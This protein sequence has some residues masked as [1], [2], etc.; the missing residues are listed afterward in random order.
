MEKLLNQLYDHCLTGELASVGIVLEWYWMQP[1]YV[2]YGVFGTV[3][4]KDIWGHGNLSDEVEDAVLWL[5]FDRLTAWCS[6]ATSSFFCFFW[7]FNFR[8]YGFVLLLY[9]PCVLRCVNN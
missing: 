4:C 9:T 2:W 6:S 5:I 7:T 1:L 8:S 3:K